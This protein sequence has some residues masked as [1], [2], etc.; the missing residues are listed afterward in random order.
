MRALNEVSQNEGCLIIFTL[1]GF[2]FQF[3]AERPWFHP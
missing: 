2:M 3:E 1:E